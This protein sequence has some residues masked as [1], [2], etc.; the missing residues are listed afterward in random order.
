MVL[1]IRMFKLPLP[2]FGIESVN[3]YLVG[4]SLVDVGL[5]SARTLHVLIRNLKDVGLRVCDVM[6]VVVTHFHVDHLSLLPLLYDM[7]GVDVYMGWRDLD[8]IRRGASKF[9]EGILEI[10]RLNGTPVEELRFITESHPL[11][12]LREVY[13]VMLQDVVI[14]PVRDGDTIDLDG[15]FKVVEVPGHTPGSIMV[16][17]EE[18]GVALVGDV[19][20][21]I[22]TPHVVAH[23]ESKDP[24]G[25]HL[26]SLKRIATM[27]LKIAYPG[28]RDP[29][30]NPAMR[31]LEILEF[32]EARLREVL[33]LVRE[34]PRT[35][36]D[37]AKNVKWRVKYESWNV[38]PLVER[39]F[40]IGEAI[41]HLEHLR[42]RRLVDYY[43]ERGVKYWYTLNS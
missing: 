36:Y 18:E 19:L 14:K 22:I 3:V 27:S 4:R 17:N 38:Y 43:E 11:L 6:N 40:A 34:K 1:D 28:H 12:R 9:V 31:A 20:I 13:D 23:I 39:F 37:V 5:Y 24:L 21:S 30:K 42:E 8:I 35:G 2:G 32:H 10:Y 33:G 7:C 16:V 41:A 29:L 26:R 15:V 25:D